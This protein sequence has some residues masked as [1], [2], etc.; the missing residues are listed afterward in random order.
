MDNEKRIYA[1]EQALETHAEAKNP[2]TNEVSFVDLLE[3][4]LHYANHHKIDFDAV[5]H[6]ARINFEAEQ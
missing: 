2:G 6:G 4:M 5:L 1:A 3:D